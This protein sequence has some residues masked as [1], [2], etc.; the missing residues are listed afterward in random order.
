MAMG[1][2]RV[3]VTVEL[4]EVASSGRLAIY[5]GAGLSRSSPTDLPGGA[6][7]AQSCHDRLVDLLGPDVL[8]GAN[9]YDLVSVAD[10]VEARNGDA[11]IVR[12]TAVDIAGFTAASPNSGHRVLALLLL[13][14]IATVITTNWDDCIERAGDETHTSTT[15]ATTHCAG[16]SGA[17]RGRCSAT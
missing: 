15:R 16:S 1:E 13:E 12:R 10:T 7:V 6:E 11:N 9:P 8:S 5:A 14:G 17:C 2:G 4:A 3:P